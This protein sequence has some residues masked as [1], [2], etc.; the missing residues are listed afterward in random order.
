[1]EGYETVAVIFARE[2][3][4]PLTGLVRV[5]DRQLA[6]APPRAKNQDKLGVFVVF[7]TDDPDMPKR[8]R[9]LI[10]AEGLEHV[11][12]CTFAASGPRRY[13]IAGE[14]DLTVLVYTDDTVRANFVLR[15][16]ELDRD[17]EADLSKA[18][19]E[20]LPKK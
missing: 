1:V 3:S 9:K 20:A 12:L 15:R 5:I 6:A 10:D 16:G 7:C 11:T 17:K 18:V 14:A 8:L 2:I 19:A 4:D 13:R